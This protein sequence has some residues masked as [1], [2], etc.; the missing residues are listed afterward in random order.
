[1]SDRYGM[2]VWQS[3]LENNNSEAQRLFW[4]YGPDRKDTTIIG[5][6]PYPES[7]KN[8]AY[9]RVELSDLPK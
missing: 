6:D 3:Y 1:M 2:K 5:L 8:G 4:V 7:Y 9:D